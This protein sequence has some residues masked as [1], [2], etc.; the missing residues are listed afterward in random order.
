[1][2]NSYLALLPFT[3]ATLAMLPSCMDDKYDL[4]DV[5]TQVEVKVTDLTVPVNIDPIKLDNV[6]E[7]K[8]G[9]RIQIID[10]YYAVKES[11]EFNTG[12]INIERIHLNAPHIDSSTSV[13]NLSNTASVPG[14]RAAAGEF[15]FN[16]T[17]PFSNYEY[18]TSTVSEFIVSI[19]QIGTE[20]TF[21]IDMSFSGLENIIKG[22]DVKNIKLQIPTGLLLHTSEGSYD[23]ATGVYSLPYVRMN[24]NRLNIHLEATA[25]DASQAGIDYNYTAHSAS[26]KGKVGVIGGELIVKESD[27]NGSASIPSSV[28]LRSDY[29]MSDIEVTFFSGEIDYRITDNVFT[30]I[31]L[32]SLPDFLAQ[33]GTDIRIVNPQLYLD[34]YNPLYS[35]SLYADT[36]LDIT[37]YG[38]DGV[39]RSYSPDAGAFRVQGNPANPWVKF[40]LS[41]EKP[42]KWFEGYADAT[43]ILFSGLSDV[44]SGNGLPHKLS[45]KLLNPQV[46]RQ[47]VKNL[48]LGVNLGNVKGHYT[49]FAPLNLKAGS[50]VVYSKRESGWSSEDLDAVTINS[51]E[52]NVNVTTDIPLGVNFTG[53]PIDK[54]GHRINNVEILGAQVQPNA[55]KQQVRIHITGEIKNLDGIEFVATAVAGSAQQPLNPNMSII[56]TDLRAKVSGVYN[57]KL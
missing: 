49:F 12:E 56:L 1:M 20:F 11:G 19:D 45:V 9:D 13:I 7:V 30:D 4:S 41:P 25:I 47:K 31:D 2:R 10:G 51:L 24:H 28:T 37:S 21:D 44:L 5:D 6:I 40:C 54:E 42:S 17:T 48:R 8:E 29:R 15:V 23:P 57:K 14:R 43:H 34:V 16:L 26:L 18:F 46:P 22:A 35:Y 33:D 3:A 36:G 50:A 53:Y 55:D 38:R 27:L 39:E 32:S 52:V